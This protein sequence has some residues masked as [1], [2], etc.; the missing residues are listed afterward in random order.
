M[1]KRSFITRE[2]YRL[3]ASDDS[4]RNPV[5]TERLRSSIV[6]LPEP[7]GSLSDRASAD[8]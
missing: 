2:G 5:K 8:A 7:K 6:S 3:Q 1:E 4:Q